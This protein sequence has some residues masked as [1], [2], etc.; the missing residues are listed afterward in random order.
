V[1]LS[2]LVLKYAPWSLSKAEVLARC[3]SQ[4]TFKYVRKVK[5]SHKGTQARVGVTAHTIQEF[6]L[7]R[8]PEPEV[9]TAFSREQMQIDQLTESEVVEVSG[10]IPGIVDFVKNM[11]R[12]KE[13][14]GAKKEYIEAKLAMTADFQ[15]CSFDDPKCLIRGVLDYGLH[16]EAGVLLL[17]D[18]KSGKRKPIEQHSM[19][20]YVYMLLAIANMPDIL[21]VQCAI[22][23]FGAPELDWF[24]TFSGRPGPWTRDDIKKHVE[25]WLTRYLSKLASPLLLVDRDEPTPSTGWQCEYCGYNDESLCPKGAEQVAERKAKRSGVNPGV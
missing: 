22:N 4:F 12:I 18:H 21:G 19:Q 15:G 7:L 11:K 20:F 2:P 8:L 1:I 23:Y 25:P 14:Y 13:M 6:A 24:P 9:L 5:E 3:S 16:T 10:K 17:V